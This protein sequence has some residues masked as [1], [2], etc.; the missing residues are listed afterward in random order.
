MKSKLLTWMRYEFSSNRRCQG[1]GRRLA[2]PM[3]DRILATTVDAPGVEAT[4]RCQSLCVLIARTAAALDY[5]PAQITGWPKAKG[6]FVVGQTIQTMPLVIRA[7]TT[8][9]AMRRM[10]MIVPS[11]SYGIKFRTLHVGGGVAMDIR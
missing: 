10:M 7:R 2:S 3:S 1:Q 8:T 11:D 6:H 5:Q 4:G 9:R